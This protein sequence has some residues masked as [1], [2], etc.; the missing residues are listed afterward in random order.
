MQNV[1]QVKSFVDD[2][3][4]KLGTVSMRVALVLRSAEVQPVFQDLCIHCASACWMTILPSLPP[5]C[6]FKKKSPSDALFGSP[7]NGEIQGRLPL[8]DATIPTCT[9]KVLVGVVVFYL[10]LEHNA[11]KAF[12]YANQPIATQAFLGIPFSTTRGFIQSHHSDPTTR[13]DG[14]TKRMN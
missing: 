10:P 5:L 7:H 13:S 1:G 9:K 8:S 12:L 3:V 2:L 14:A 11:L 6:P 4:M